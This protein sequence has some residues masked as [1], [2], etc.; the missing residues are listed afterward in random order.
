MSGTAASC[1]CC[2]C[3]YDED[4]YTDIKLAEL[5]KIVQSYYNSERIMSVIMTLFLVGSFIG[6]ALLSFYYE[7]SFGDIVILLGYLGWPIALAFASIIRP[8]FGRHPSI[9]GIKIASY[10]FGI[11]ICI[12]YIAFR[13]VFLMHC[14]D[15]DYLATHVCTNSVC[16]NSQGAAIGFMAYAGAEAIVF[17]VA[18]TIDSFL[19]RPAAEYEKRRQKAKQNKK[20]L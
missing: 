10:W 19:W 14:G 16:Q 6:T 15:P 3:T 9:I 7:Y 4:A 20:K 1:C 2:C 18:A 17:F 12:I 8:K 13:G 5:K 11:A